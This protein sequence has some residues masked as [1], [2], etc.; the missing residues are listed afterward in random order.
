MPT[1]TITTANS[2]THSVEA[3][4]PAMAVLA[5]CRTTGERTFNCAILARIVEPL[6]ECSTDSFGSELRARGARVA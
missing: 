3:D 2:G 5:V 1:Y 6:D 4:D